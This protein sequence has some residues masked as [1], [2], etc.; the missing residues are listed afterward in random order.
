MKKIIYAAILC[1]LIACFSGCNNSKA[2]TDTQEPGSVFN[3]VYDTYGN[4]LQ[5]SIYN[6]QTGETVTTIFTYQRV[7]GQ[8]V[9]V[10]QQVIVT[11][12]LVTSTDQTKTQTPV[13]T[14]IIKDDNLPEVLID[15]KDVT[16]SVVEKLDQE[17]WW[18]F[19]YELKI[20]NHNDK[21]VSVLFNNVSIGNV[22]SK[23]LFNVDQI[24]PGYTNYFN[25][26]WDKDSLTKDSVPYLNDVEFT[27]SVYIG[28]EN[29]KQPAKYG[30]QVLI[31]D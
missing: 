10:D 14:L 11:S 28:T 15:N 8:W 29:W 7:N 17:S 4:I 30:I 3:T 5:Q 23:P 31:Q 18:E 20:E 2:T 19:G 22:Y 9:C 25:L 24:E 27:L 21:A 26:A 6:E 12:R 13:N 16:I 1:L